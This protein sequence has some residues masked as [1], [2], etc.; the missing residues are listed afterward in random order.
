M[1]ILSIPNYWFF[2][3]NRLERTTNGRGF[4]MEKSLA[5]LRSLDA[6]EGERIPFLREVFDVVDRQAAINVELKGIHTAVP[7]AELI[8]E[9]I[10][11]GW[12]Y[13]HFLVSSFNHHELKRIKTIDA[14]IRIGVLIYGL[15]ID[16]AQ[17]GEALDAFSIH[18]SIDFLDEHFINDAHRRGLKVIAYTANDPQDIARMKKLGVDGLF[19]NYP[20]RI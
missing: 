8:R 9:Y 12:G 10:A 13:E 6:G 2:H 11:K 1:F 5:Y 19:S 14:N 15:P 7:V 4:I 16:Y 18:P 3:D 17:Q 20:E